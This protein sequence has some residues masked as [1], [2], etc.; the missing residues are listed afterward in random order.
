MAFS[1][2]GSPKPAFFDS[3]GSPLA[4]G[5]LSVLE[6]AD[7]SNKTYYPTAD[8]ADAGTNGASG[9]ITLDSRGETPNAFF[10]VNG[11]DYKLV[12]K[13]S[14]G[15][16]IWTVD[17]VYAGVGA[18]RG[19]YN[20][21][22]AG[23][24]STT[25]ESKLQERVTVKDFGAVGDG[26]TD[27]TAAIQA[28]IDIGGTL[29]IPDGVY[30]FTNFDLT[31]AG[32]TIY[33]SRDAIL[34]CTVSSGT[35]FA[36]HVRADNIEIRGVTIQG[37]VASDTYVNGNRAIYGNE[38]I[39]TPLTYL[40]RIR[41]HDVH[42]KNFGD[43]GIR[44][45]YLKDSRI[46][47]NEIEE[48]GSHGIFL[49]AGSFDNLISENYVHDIK[50]GV[51]GG[52]VD[53]Y[54]PAYGIAI[55]RDPAKDI[56]D[57]PISRRNQIVNNKV[58]NVPSWNG[59]DLHGAW[60]TLISGNLIQ[61]CSICIHM[62]DGDGPVAPTDNVAVIRANIV[63]NVCI[64]NA[65]TAFKVGP[66]INLK[67]ASDDG[68][69]DQG[70]INIT[71]NL[72]IECGWETTGIYSTSHGA[73]HALRVEGLTVSGNVISAPYGVGVYLDGVESG[74][75]SGNSIKNTQTSSGDTYGILF[76]D[77][78]NSVVVSNN[79]FFGATP[80][81]HIGAI[82]T[83]DAGYN[84][85]IRDNNFFG[86]GTAYDANVIASVVGVFGSGD[87][88]PSVRGGV[89]FE[90]TGTTAITDFDDGVVGQTIR[91]K[92]NASITITNG[93]PIDLAGGMD[94]SMTAEDVLV[95]TMFDDQVW[96]EVSRSVN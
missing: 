59:I 56:T 62:E 83:P 24:V 54:Y 72:L 6:P 47:G 91:V 8:D 46:S 60:E 88:T 51:T 29:Y 45:D 76:G 78:D 65:G 12:L 82:S 1:I 80:Q 10:G 11:E 73:I 84:F 43:H 27:D 85:S 89:N 36:L 42:I 52:G 5:T 20:Q 95:L 35:N 31:V 57:A 26:V 9:D 34:N 39:V 40:N 16:T 75:I 22:G 79:T 19:S 17:D 2:L 69:D 67:G 23:A 3:N 53:P 49:G 64:G 55:T 90:T 48:C 14:A 4:S 96:H 44:F 58:V 93:A 13:D 77:G 38:D 70:D 63:N 33:G 74:V 50:P 81:I 41:I 68:V 32:T 21:G 37:S 71:G 28:A 30:N 66:G 7:N 92:A 87:A 25:I 18:N 15:T 86:S 94:Y 61:R